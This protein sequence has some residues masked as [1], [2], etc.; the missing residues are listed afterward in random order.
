[1]AKGRDAHSPSPR[2]HRS[3]QDS[4]ILVASTQSTGLSAWVRSCSHHQLLPNCRGWRRGL[5]V[6]GLQPRW[7]ATSA[8]SHS[9]FQ[10][11]VLFTLL[12]RFHLIPHGPQLLGCLSQ[13]RLS[14]GAPPQRSH[15]LFSALLFW[16]L[17]VHS[18]R[19]LISDACALFLLCLQGI[20]SSSPFG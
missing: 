13:S 10:P 11:E 1:M 7:L 6:L 9:F 18:L 16:P 5:E 20:D 17:S 19:M 14:L 15:R 12:S 4:Q 2:A 8:S 3:S